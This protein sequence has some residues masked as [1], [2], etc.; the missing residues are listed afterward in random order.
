MAAA[1]HERLEAAE[2]YAKGMQDDYV[3][4]EH[5]LLEADREQRSKRLSQYGLTK[6][7]SCKALTGI[8][9]TQRVTSATPESTYQSLKVRARPDCAGAAGQMG[10][11][12][13]AR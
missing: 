10:P 7:P 3:S 9:G 4:A 13:R 6:D 2:R 1:H 5:L 8:R 12:D 11:G